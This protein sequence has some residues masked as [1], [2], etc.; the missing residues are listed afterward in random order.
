MLTL[1]ENPAFSAPSY[2][3]HAVCMLSRIYY[4]QNKPEEVS[5]ILEQTSTYFEES[6]N[7]TSLEIIRAF[8]VELALDQGD[9]VRAN[10]LSSLVD[11]NARP[12]LWFYYVSQLTPIKILL[13]QQTPSHLEQAQSNLEQFEEDI[14]AL[15]RKTIHIDVLALQALAYEAQENWQKA[16]EKLDMALRL[17]QPGGFIRN[18][19]DLG[20]PMASLMSRLQKQNN[21]AMGSYDLPDLSCFSNEGS[22]SP[23]FLF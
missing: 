1:L 3:A 4:Y 2:L 21:T 12:P 17:A 9:F 6:W 15:N 22:K 13:A 11:F 23:R 20:P 5:R 16:A 19:V 10:Y 18:F 14:H 8:E 7:W